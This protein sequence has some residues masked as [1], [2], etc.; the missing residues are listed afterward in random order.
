MTLKTRQMRTL[1]GFF[2]NFELLFCIL[3]VLKFSG[4]FFY[5][6]ILQV[7]RRFI[8]LSTHFQARAGILSDFQLISI[9]L[10]CGLCS[11]QSNYHGEMKWNA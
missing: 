3:S 5:V 4:R 1:F 7:I 6:Y 9:I 10:L 8:P 2:T 11:N